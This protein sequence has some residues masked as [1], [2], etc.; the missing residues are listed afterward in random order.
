VQ[1]AAVRLSRLQ[2]I[3][4]TADVCAIADCR[5]TL[6]HGRRPD[7]QDYRMAR[8]ALALIAAPIGRSS[9]GRGRVMIWRLKADT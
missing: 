8:K 6:L 3:L 7:P 4:S 9:R 1:L 5:K 2:S